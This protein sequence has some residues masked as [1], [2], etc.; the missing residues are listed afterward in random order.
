MRRSDPTPPHITGEP[1]PHLRNA[2]Y[3]DSEPSAPSVAFQL[4]WRRMI[5]DA[6][7]PHADPDAQTLS[8]PTRGGRSQSKKQAPSSGFVSASSSGRAA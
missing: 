1:T 8:A 3:D 5:T 2:D 6:P 7:G 4:S